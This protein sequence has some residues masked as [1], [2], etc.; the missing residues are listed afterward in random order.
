MMRTALIALLLLL[1][2][3]FAQ[4]QLIDYP[5]GQTFP[6][7]FWV[8]PATH[9]PAQPSNPASPPTLTCPF[10]TYSP[11]TAQLSGAHTGIYTGFFE[12]ETE[13]DVWINGNDVT[14]SVRMANGL[15]YSGTSTLS[16][17]YKDATVYLRNNFTTAIQGSALLCASPGPYIAPPPARPKQVIGSGCH[18]LEIALAVPGRTITAL[19]FMRTT[20]PPRTAECFR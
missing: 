10:G 4:A 18:R 7:N 8:P 16:G 11:Q 19:P 5:E 9:Q 13:V 20:S 15:W 6:D 17:S 12:P 3:P 1:V 14:V 2:S